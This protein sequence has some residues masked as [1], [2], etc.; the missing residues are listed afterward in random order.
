MSLSLTKSLDKYSRANEQG[1]IEFS[2][3]GL[4]PRKSQA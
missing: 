2:K 3:L 1:E 4:L